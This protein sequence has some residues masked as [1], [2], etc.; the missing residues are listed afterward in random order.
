M[1]RRDRNQEENN[2][3][4]DQHIYENET[5]DSSSRQSRQQQNKGGNTRFLTILVILLLLLIS[6][7]TGAY[8]LVTRDTGQP[9]ATPASTTQVTSESSSVESSESSTEESSTVES[10]ESSEAPVESAPSQAQ[11]EQTTPSEPESSADEATGNEQFATVQAG[12]GLQQ[13]SQRTG[14]PVEEIARLNGITIQGGTFSP[15]INPGQQL[16]IK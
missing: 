3:P 5:E 15:A 7:P 10:S 14:V 6:I 11:P 12:D 13:I 8:F 2:E 1:S 9:A 16:R 4:W